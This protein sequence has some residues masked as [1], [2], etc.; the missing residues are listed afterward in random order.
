MIDQGAD[1]LYAERFGVS[2]AAK[3]RGVKAIGNVIDTQDQYPGTVVA[4]ALW[5]M[6]P[7]ID[8]ALAAVKGGTL[9]GRGLR[10]AEQPR[11]RRLLVAPIN[12]G[13]RA[14]RR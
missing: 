1:V 4:S 2:D 3:E 12:A 14:D 6:E 7:S 10:P 9:Q 5:H 13:A 11:G 8:K